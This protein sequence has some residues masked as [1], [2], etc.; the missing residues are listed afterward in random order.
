MLRQTSQSGHVY[1]GA[2]FPHVPCVLPGLCTYTATS[3]H[4]F[5]HFSKTLTPY[6]THCCVGGWSSLCCLLHILSILYHLTYALLLRYL[7]P[8]SWAWPWRQA[9]PTVARL[10]GRQAA[11]VPLPPLLSSS[12][13]VVV[14]DGPSLRCGKQHVCIWPWLPPFYPYIKQ[15]PWHMRQ[16]PSQILFWFLAVARHPPRP[17]AWRDA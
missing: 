7:C 14:D 17:E 12:F 16:P 9:G 5:T 15:K 8:A 2:K 13:H 4:A 1:G 3:R 11:C 10:P 6:C